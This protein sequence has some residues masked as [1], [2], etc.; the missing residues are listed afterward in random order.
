MQ[1]HLPEAPKKRYKVDPQ[2]IPGEK[3]R[4]FGYR[5]SKGTA[6]NNMNMER[7]LQERELKKVYMH[8]EKVKT[9]LDMIAYL[10]HPKYEEAVKEY[11]KVESGKEISSAVCKQ[12]ES[13]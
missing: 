8:G 9:R 10:V 6:I 2:K 5:N 1:A 11:Q 4:D 12:R 3:W 7:P 13:Q